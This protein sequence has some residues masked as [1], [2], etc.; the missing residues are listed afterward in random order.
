M[1]RVSV[2]LP[3]YNYAQYL[4]ERIRSILNQTVTDFEL[5]YLDDASTDA[6]NEIAKQFT[7]DQRMRLVLFAD[8]AGKVY[9]RWNE[10]AAL[11]CGEWLWFAGADDTAHPR[12]LERM[13]EAADA[14]PT[15]GII[16]C[17]MATIDS[18]GRLVGVQWAADPELQAHMENDY[19]APG[20]E[21]AI[22]LTSGCF[23]S[24]ASAILLRRADFMA[25]GGFD[26]RLWS[27]ADWHL[28][29]TMLQFCDIAYCSEPLVC[30]RAHQ[31]TVTKKTKAAIRGIED[32]YC[33]AAAYGWMQK[34][35]RLPPE[36][37]EGVLRRV[38]SRLFDLFA[39]PSVEI[40]EELRFAVETIH[41]VVPDG[42]LLRP[43][44]DRESVCR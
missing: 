41:R 14:H 18:A 22:R 2:V 4:K 29:L 8:N 19:G 37:R 15:A 16:H 32:A 27:A 33:I 5:L 10:G 3:N 28:Y 43:G 21:E 11:A 25:A 7:D 20:Y 30:Y 38:K 26:V 23:L 17:R 13:L 36:P 24:S 12:F 6:S 42:R 9:Q 31:A 34:D 35:S 44:N 40:P 1:P 39:D